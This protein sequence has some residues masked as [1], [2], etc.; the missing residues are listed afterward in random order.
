MM[1]I[2]IAYEN[3]IC[4]LDSR[5]NMLTKKWYVPQIYE[6]DEPTYL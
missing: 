5:G 3:G 2:M 4:N 6:W 1:G